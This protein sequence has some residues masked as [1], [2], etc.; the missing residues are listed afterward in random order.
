MKTQDQAIRE[1]Y[2]VDLS[3]PGRPMGARGKYPDYE[4]I[5]LFTE[6][7]E[8]LLNTLGLIRRMLVEGTPTAQAREDV[9]HAIDDLLSLARA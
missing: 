5:P 1:G 3:G 8:E 6:M 2:D 7:E 4:V 9:V